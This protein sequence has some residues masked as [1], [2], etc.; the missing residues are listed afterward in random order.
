VR[1]WTHEHEIV[2]IASRQGT[3]VVRR[4]WCTH[5]V[6][7][8]LVGGVWLKLAA[9]EMMGG[10]RWREGRDELLAVKDKFRINA[11]ER[12]DIGYCYWLGHFT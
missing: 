10:R 8:P 11:R 3:G 9:G 2:Y 6:M 4:L 7:R 12:V 5:H 1:A